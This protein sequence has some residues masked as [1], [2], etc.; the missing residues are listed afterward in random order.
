MGWCCCVN[1]VCSVSN[2]ARLLHLS[3]TSFVFYVLL[4]A[5]ESGKKL[6]TYSFIILCLSCIF[7]IELHHAWKQGTSK[8]IMIIVLLSLST[9]CF[10]IASLIDPGY[11][12]FPKDT[13]SSLFTL[14][15]DTN[16]VSHYCQQP[17]M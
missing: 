15:H 6:Y 3:L 9:I 8:F 5:P 13:P 17:L 2:C 7:I 16:K 1:R 11:E 12:P 4:I 14:K 10:L